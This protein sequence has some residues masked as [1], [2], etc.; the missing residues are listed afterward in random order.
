M[1][2]F[3]SETCLKRLS[4]PT[5]GN[6]LISRA[7]ELSRIDP[8]ALGGFEHTYALSPSAYAQ[9]DDQESLESTANELTGIHAKLYIA[10]VGG[11]AR[12]WTGSANCLDGVPCTVP[13]A[14]H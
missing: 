13:V 8:T 4:D 7:E 9:E 1:A 10:E 14:F 2:P 11:T 6:V 5:E 12:I 3:L